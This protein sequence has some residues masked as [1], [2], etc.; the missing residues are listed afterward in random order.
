MVKKFNKLFEEKSSDNDEI[1]NLYHKFHAKRCV[2]GMLYLLKT[3][4]IDPNIDLGDGS[5]LA[6][7][8]EYESHI[9]N[10]DIDSY[11]DLVKYL[12]DNGADINCLDIDGKPPIL[13]TNYVDVQNMLLDADCDLNMKLDEDWDNEDILEI[14]HNLM[15]LVKTNYPENYKKYLKKKTAKKFK[16]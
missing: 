1:E 13:L 15:K 9:N 16:I 14:S 10:S 4:D 7:L 6:Y 12:I 11:F 2:S 3:T 8:D 5:T